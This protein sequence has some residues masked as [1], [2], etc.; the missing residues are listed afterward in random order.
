MTGQDV[1]K[2]FVITNM[3]SIVRRFILDPTDRAKIIYAYQNATFILDENI[4]DE[5]PEEE[6]QQEA[7]EDEQQRTEDNKCTYDEMKANLRE[8][9]KRDLRKVPNMPL[10]W[11]VVDAFF[12]ILTIHT[13]PSVDGVGL[14]ARLEKPLGKR[15]QVSC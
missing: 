2:R 7:P 11:N 13:I 5:L 8:V 10:T 12:K 14:H 3:S 1:P 15:S 9:V 6:Q 4:P